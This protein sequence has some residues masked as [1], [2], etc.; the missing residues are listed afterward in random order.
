MPATSNLRSDEATEYERRL[1][2]AVLELNLELA[3][4][5]RGGNAGEDY[6]QWLS[7]RVIALSLEN[8]DLRRLVTQQ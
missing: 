7:D 6:V 3:R 4:A 8:M 5:T 2:R 1:E